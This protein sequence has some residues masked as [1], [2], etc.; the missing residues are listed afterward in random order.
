MTELIGIKKGVKCLKNIGK[1]LIQQM[2][3]FSKYW[4][5]RNTIDWYI[6]AS[7]KFKFGKKRP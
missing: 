7:K 5:R 2:F 4:R 1:F 6:I 3:Y